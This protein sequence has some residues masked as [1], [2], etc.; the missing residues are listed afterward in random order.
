[1]PCFS[2]RRILTIAALFVATAALHA[3]SANTQSTSSQS[4]RALTHDDYD[5]WKSLRGTTYSQDGNWVAYQVEPQF[6][7]GVLEIRQVA[8]EAK[9]SEPLASGARFSVDG[10]YVVFTIGKS[11]VAER[12]KK[13]AD[14]RKKAKEAKEGKKPGAEKAEGETKP[15]GEAGAA[16]ASRRGPWWCSRWCRRGGVRRPRWSG[17][18]GWSAWSGWCWRARGG[19]WRT[20]WCRWRRSW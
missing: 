6:G 17:C 8:G 10:R 19:C 5:Q 3:Q 15:E 1:M 9:F 4:P 7:D 14:L 18:C 11:K 2:A 16:E 12:D 13:I 20:W